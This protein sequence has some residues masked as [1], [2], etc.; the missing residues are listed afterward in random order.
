MSFRPTTLA[1][2]RGVGFDGT[3]SF[4]SEAGPFSFVLKIIPIMAYV[5]GLLCAM[6]P[7]CFRAS[8]REASSQLT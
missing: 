1:R 4:F 6:Q 3:A 7:R 8:N 2:P 5:S